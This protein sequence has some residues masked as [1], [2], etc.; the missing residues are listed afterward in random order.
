VGASKNR[1]KTGNRGSFKKGDARINKKGR[2]PLT[3]EQREFKEL[4][5]QKSTAALERLERIGKRTQID[6]LGAAT[7]AN[8]AIIEHAWG[9]PK[10]EVEV[11]GDL[12][13]PTLFL[14]EKEPE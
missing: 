10:Q 2:P 11:G 8:K 4:C 1:R 9:K 3:P 13:V 12:R 6:A 5:K 14:P 7:N